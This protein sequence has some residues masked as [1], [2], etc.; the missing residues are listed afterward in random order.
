MVLVS[1]DG[2]RPDYLERVETPAFDR[3]IRTGII[4]DGLISVFPSLTFPAHYSIA[5]GLYPEHHGIVGN[6]F[7]DPVS[8]S[9]FDYRDRDDAGD[10]RWWG[11][12]P[13]WVTAETQG[14]VSAALF[15]PGTEADIHEIRP[16]HWRPYDSSFRNTDRVQQALEWLVAPP[17]E[18]PHLVTLYFSLVD[19]IGHRSGPDG[20]QLTGAISAADRLL[21]QLLDGIERMPHGDQVYVVVVSDHGM[22]AIDPERQVVLPEIAG[23]RGVRRVSNG[24]VVSLYLD[25]DDERGRQIRDDVNTGTT[26]ATAYLRRDVPEHLHYRAHP[27]IGDVVVIPEEGA[28]VRFRSDSAPPL[29]MH[30]WDPTL[31]S[32][33]GIFLIRGPGLSP[34]QH[35]GPFES[36]DIYPLLAQVL[37]LNPPSDLDGHPG[38]LERLLKPYRRTSV[39]TLSTHVAF[40][41]GQIYT[42]RLRARGRPHGPSHDHREVA[43]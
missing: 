40:R 27:R 30:G 35:I 1:F 32:M 8:N 41:F 34:G 29:G 38:L 42:S 37:G 15:F 13:I 24:P 10:G 17:P 21:G 31:V 26:L 5:T 3:L 6:R 14:M 9:D 22:A 39:L 11:G 16:T 33:H 28:S 20:P 23:L 36:V 43:P 4:A 19:G 25:G 18:R 2:F 12:E 7:H